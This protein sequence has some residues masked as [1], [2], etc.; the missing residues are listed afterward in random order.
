MAHDKAF[1]RIASELTNL[2]D[3]EP[4]EELAGGVEVTAKMLAHGFA[5]VRC[6]APGRLWHLRF[7][8]VPGVLLSGYRIDVFLN[9]CLLGVVVRVISL[10]L[11]VMLSLFELREVLKFVGSCRASQERHRRPRFRDIIATHFFR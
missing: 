1:V 9:R 2:V 5:R 11:E 7:A 8:I 10:V 4:A 3:H 6:E